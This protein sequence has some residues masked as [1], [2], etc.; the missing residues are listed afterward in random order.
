MCLEKP[1]VLQQGILDFLVTGQGPKFIQTQPIH[2]L[3]FR[4]L[5]VLDPAFREYSCC[6][7][8]NTLA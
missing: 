3:A 7:H 5:K 8:G 6:F 4:G 1:Q 2:R